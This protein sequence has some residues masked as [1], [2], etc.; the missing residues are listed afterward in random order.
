MKGYVVFQ[1]RASSVDLRSGYCGVFVV[2]VPISR[3]DRRP[4]SA[5]CMV[6]ANSFLSVTLKLILLATAS[7]FPS[8]A[9]VE[10]LH[11]KTEGER[12]LVSIKL[13]RSKPWESEEIISN[14]L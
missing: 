9:E 4:S 13:L 10:N 8:T 3:C 6:S 12:F 1:G 2:G 7:S 5:P 14:A 11:I